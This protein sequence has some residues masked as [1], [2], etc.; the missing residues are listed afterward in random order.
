MKRERTGMGLN[1]QGLS[2]KVD[3][4][5]RLTGDKTVQGRDHPGDSDEE[6]EG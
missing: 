1:G 5:M 2:N 6:D 3:L 4:D